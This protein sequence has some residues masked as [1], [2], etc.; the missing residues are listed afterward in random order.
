M[1]SLIKYIKEALIVEGGNA[2]NGTPMTQTQA[3]AVFEDVAKKLLPKLG[4]FE[5]GTDY[6]ALGSFGKKYENKTTF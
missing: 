2:V 5:K 3:K 1:K 4:C 6:E